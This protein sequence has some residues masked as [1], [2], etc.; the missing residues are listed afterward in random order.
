[1][2]GFKYTHTMPEI[3]GIKNLMNKYNS[4]IATAILTEGSSTLHSTLEAILISF[5]IIFYARF[6]LYYS[7]C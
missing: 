3:I 2:Y 7:R 1:M 4:G 5:V 6:F